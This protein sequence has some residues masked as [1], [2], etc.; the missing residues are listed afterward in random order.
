MDLFAI[1][2]ALLVPAVQGRALAGKSHGHPQ[3]FPSGG[4]HR[5]YTRRVGGS[6]LRPRRKEDGLC[7]GL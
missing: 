7:P 4:R 1:V 5:R 6:E 2:V 3:R